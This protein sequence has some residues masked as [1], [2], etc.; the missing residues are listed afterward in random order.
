MRLKIFSDVRYLPED[1]NPTLLL[2]PF[3][4]GKRANSLPPWEKRLSNY[5]EISHSLFE[6][7]SLEEADFA[8]LPFDWVDV[9]GH[10]WKTKINQ[11]AYALGIEFVQKV[12]QA[13]K[14]L[15]I[16]YSGDRSHD[17][18]PIQNAIVF[19]QSIIGPRRQ[20]QEF[21]FI[22]L[23]EDLVQYYLGNEL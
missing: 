8:V 1:I 7:T 15:I 21:A 23:Y 3:R 11:S 12:K 18:I 14:P 17:S 16:F 19:R 9:T 20:L 4:L 10:S 22:A 5:T 6:I 2:E 13:G